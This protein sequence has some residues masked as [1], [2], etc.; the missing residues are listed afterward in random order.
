MSV[1]GTLRCFSYESEEW[2]RPTIPRNRPLIFLADRWIDMRQYGVGQSR[3][4][5]PHVFIIQISKNFLS[6]KIENYLM[7]W[8]LTTTFFLENEKNNIIT[9]FDVGGTYFC[10]WEL[11]TKI[12]IGRKKASRLPSLLLSSWCYL[13]LFDCVR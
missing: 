8:L 3:I 11:R 2:P 12:I 7:Q 10:Y 6:R 9:I 1:S 13:I 4:R 5:V